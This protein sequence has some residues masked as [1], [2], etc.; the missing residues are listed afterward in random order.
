MACTIASQG[1]EYGLIGHNVVLM[2]SLVEELKAPEL[3]LRPLDGNVADPDMQE[4]RVKTQLE[5]YVQKFFEILVEDLSQRGIGRCTTKIERLAFMLDPRYKGEVGEEDGI[6]TV[7]EYAD[8]RDELQTLYD[9]LVRW[10]HDLDKKEWERK[11]SDR[12][13][14]VL[15]AEAEELRRQAGATVQRTIVVRPRLRALMLPPPLTR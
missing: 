7:E 6:L 8:A 15:M 5:P 9:G 3:S 10:R 13:R 1:H 12:R 11:Q 4:Q 2:H 14:R